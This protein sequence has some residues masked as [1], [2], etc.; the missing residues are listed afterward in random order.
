MRGDSGKGPRDWLEA[1]GAGG[2]GAGG[3]VDR[4]GRSGLGVG[5]QKEGGREMWARGGQV[6]L[7]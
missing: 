3:G 1:G 2:G 7:V 5:G 6:A 4:R